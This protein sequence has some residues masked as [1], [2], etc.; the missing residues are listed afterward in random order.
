MLLVNLVI[1]KVFFIPLQQFNIKSNDLLSF[2]AEM[3]LNFS[4]NQHKTEV[5]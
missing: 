3:L 1:I 5:F 2:E 4:I